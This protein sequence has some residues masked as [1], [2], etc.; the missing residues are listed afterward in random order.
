MFKPDVFLINTTQEEPT[1]AFL[2]VCQ[3]KQGTRFTLQGTVLLSYWG[4]YGPFQK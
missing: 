1:Q 3:T 4:F 2:H